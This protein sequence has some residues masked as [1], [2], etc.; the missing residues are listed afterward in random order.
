M[1]LNVLQQVG[2]GG[3]SLLEEEAG[4]G[5]FLLLEKTVKLPWGEVVLYLV[6]CLPAFWLSPLGLRVLVCGWGI[7]LEGW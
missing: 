3:G 2:S 5:V 1:A 4:V 7:K 6:A